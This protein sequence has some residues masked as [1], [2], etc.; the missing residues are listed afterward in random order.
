MKN[1]RNNNGYHHRI[2]CLPNH[3]CG[4]GYWPVRI[5][6]MLLSGSG[7][8]LELDPDPVSYSCKFLSRIKNQMLINPSTGLNYN[9]RVEFIFDNLAVSRAGSE[10]GTI[11]DQDPDWNPYK[12]DRGPQY[13]YIHITNCDISK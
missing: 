8:T 5:T 12:S 9:A 13:G 10:S 7:S 6:I 3:C 2:F 4:F 1:H 11:S